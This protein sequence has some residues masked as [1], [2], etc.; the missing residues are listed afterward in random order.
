MAINKRCFARWWKLTPEK[1]RICSPTRSKRTPIR[2]IGPLLLQL[3]T[4]RKAIVLNRAAVSDVHESNTL[5]KALSTEGQDSLVP[6]LLDVF[7][8]AREG[9][10]MKFTDRCNVAVIYIN[11]FIGD[12]Q[13]RRVIGVLDEL[14]KSEIRRRANS[15]YNLITR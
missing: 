6:L 2:R 1:Q 3:I 15:A 8:L 13:I 9:G 14:K 7:S 12:L 4:G 11:L 10:Q 5:G